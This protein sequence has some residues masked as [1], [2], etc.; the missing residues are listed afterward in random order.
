MFKLYKEVLSDHAGSLR[1]Y[2]YTSLY[3][4]VLKYGKYG[5][6]HPIII[7]RNFKSLDNYF[8]VVKCKVL[9]PRGIYMPMLPYRNSVGDTLY[10]PLCAR[11]CENLPKASEGRCSCSDA[12]R[13][14][15][16]E[17]T[18]I[19]VERAVTLGLKII[20]IYEVYHYPET[21][22]F[23]RVTGKGG[24]FVRYIN[25]LLKIKQESDGWPL[26]ADT[27][28]KKALYLQQYLDHEGI[29]LDPS[30]IPA[31]GKNMG[32]RTLSKLALNSLW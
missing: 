32:L 31:S 17:W 13:A 20:K 21:T 30:K 11:C 1:Y 28:E 24:V 15:I 16:G 26:D 2:D 7:T 14:L 12:E 8:G 3:P 9:W 25:A 18:T 6:G 4:Y 27:D 23:N 29:R 22:Q 19:E 5:L 10:F